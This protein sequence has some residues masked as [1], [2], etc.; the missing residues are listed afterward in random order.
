MGEAKYG[1][2]LPGAALTKDLDK[3]LILLVYNRYYNDMISV[4][5]SFHPRVVL[6]EIPLHA[7]G[8]CCSSQVDTKF[9]SR[10]R[11]GVAKLTAMDTKITIAQICHMFHL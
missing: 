9:R 8:I 6:I 10:S 4:T 2:A 1:H 11:W 5:V 3:V 7:T